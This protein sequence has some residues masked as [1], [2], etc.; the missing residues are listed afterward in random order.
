MTQKQQSKQQ[1]EKLAEANDVVYNIIPTTDNK[2]SEIKTSLPPKSLDRQPSTISTQSAIKS[3]APAS[4]SKQ[5]QLFEVSHETANKVGGIYTVIRTKAASTSKLYPNYTMIGMLNQ[6]HAS[7]EVEPSEPLN[8]HIEAAVSSMKQQGVH[9]LTGKWLIDGSPN[10]ILFDLGSSWHRLNQW[11]QELWDIGSIPSYD[12]DTEQNNAIV[13][14]FLTAWFLSEYTKNVTNA[15]SLSKLNNKN[16]KFNQSTIVHAHEWLSGVCLLLIKSWNL[17][18]STIF[19]THATLLGRYLCA[20]QVD[21]YNHLQYFNCDKE[22]GQRQIYHRYCIERASAHNCHVFTTVSHITAYESEH[23]LK[24]KPDGVTP[25]GL[26]IIKFA[27]VHE[28]QNLHQQSKL[29]INEF[30]RGHFHGHLDFD[31]NNTLY[32]FTAGRMEYRNKG[33][34]LYLESLSRLNYKL[35]QE[36]KEWEAQKNS[37]APQSPT[38]S[39]ASPV[40]TVIAFIVTSAPHHSYTVDAMKGQAVIRQLQQSI[41]DIQSKIGD[42]LLD[43]CL[44]NRLNELSN[45]TGEGAAASLLSPNDMTILKRRILQLQSST[46]PAVTTHNIVNSHS[47]E[48]LQNIRRLQL[49]NLSHD[50]VKII[51]HPE[52][53]NVNSPLFPIEYEEFVRGCH[54]GVFP[55]FYEPWGYTRNSFSFSSRMHCIRGSID[56]HQFKWIWMLY[57]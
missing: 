35:Q 52:F 2:P 39:T 31:L 3:N 37:Q 25:N 20:G 43:L 49:F 38:T 41:H 13:F 47:D 27:A 7:M 19:T 53:L 10:V 15:E 28:F 8:P 30:I 18:V 14:G 26:N 57:G 54:L 40:K 1:Q 51:Y 16:A 5:V 11:K 29:K 55:S 46:P 42:K 44:T 23:L 17:P 45:K 12:H 48:I 21:F 56:Y 22:A 4:N 33:I 36:Q 24:R 50:R 9:I 34:D 6:Q 32:F